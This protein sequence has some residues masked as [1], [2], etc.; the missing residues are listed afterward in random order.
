[1]TTVYIIF[2]G[3]KIQ[4]PQDAPAVKM[5]SAGSRSEDNLFMFVIVGVGTEQRVCPHVYTCAH[6]LMYI[7]SL[8]GAYEALKRAARGG[9]IRAEYVYSVPTTFLC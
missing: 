7:Y 2:C 1:M 3:S 6:L 5:G 9:M 8:L 4:Q